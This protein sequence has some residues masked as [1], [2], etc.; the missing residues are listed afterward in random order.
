MSVRGPDHFVLL[1]HGVN[2]FHIKVFILKIR[3]NVELNVVS[4]PSLG[5]SLLHA[6]RRRKKILIF[7]WRVVMCLLVLR[8]LQDGF[9]KLLPGV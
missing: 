4:S 8:V 7:V 5:G 2:L 3:T 1:C 6:D 9:L